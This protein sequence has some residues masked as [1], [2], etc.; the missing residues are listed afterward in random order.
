MTTGT[1]TN[2]SDVPKNIGPFSESVDEL[3]SLNDQ[4]L[5]LLIKMHETVRHPNS[6]GYSLVKNW[7]KFVIPPIQSQSQSSNINPLAFYCSI[8]N[9]TE[10]N[11]SEFNNHYPCILN[12]WQQLYKTFPYYVIQLMYNSVNEIP[13]S[14]LHNSN[15]IKIRDFYERIQTSHSKLNISKAVTPNSKEKQD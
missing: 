4:S 5:I 7:C 11:Q 8:S 13:L 15:K 12:Y 1:N 6:K 14:N 3:T 9:C 10:H 2:I